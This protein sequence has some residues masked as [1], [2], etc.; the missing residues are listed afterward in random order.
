M[1]YLALL[2]LAVIACVSLLATLIFRRVVPTNEVHILQYR[3][4]TVSF[5]K[6]YEQGNVYYQWPSWLPIIGVLVTQLPVSNFDLSV[7]AYE[8]YDKDRV[9]FLVD[10]AAFYRIEDANLAAQRVSNFEE[11]KQQLDVIQRGAVRTVLASSDIN[12]IMLERSQFGKKFTDEVDEQLKNWGL[13][14]VK[15][16]ELMDIRDTREGKTI[17]NI[18]AKK[19]SH[20]EME[21]RIEV[22]NNQQ[23]ATTKEIEAQRNV[24]ISKQD[25]M[26]AVGLRTVENERNVNV[27]KQEAQ[28]AVEEQKR[29]TREK[30]MAVT[31]V[32]DV[33]RSEIDKQVAVI[34]AQQSKETAVLV[35]QGELEA[36]KLNAQGIQ[37]TGQAKADA[38]KA[39]Q[40]APVEAQIVLA[41]EIGGNEQYQQ[42]LITV[43]QIKAG[44]VVGV[45]QAK[46]LTAAELKVIANTGDV[47]QGVTD[48]MQLFSPKGGTAVGGMLEALK[49]TDA[50]KSIVS[51][52][53]GVKNV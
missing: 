9:P 29:I 32:T 33:K 7:T 27:S 51:K 1:I 16:L 43:E 31:Q 22:A 42:Y 18:M 21:S 15:N 5:G 25:A 35:A 49:N 20:I 47:Q 24:E 40:L 11:L 39:M 2:T 6:G 17:H 8:A 34:E 13:V 14:T 12:T 28:Q 45:E 19:Q 4:T 52:L 41:K 50:G 44:Q 30:E 10:I 23:Q 37:L 3:N 46:A 36:V 48:I 38:E 53:T 26:Q